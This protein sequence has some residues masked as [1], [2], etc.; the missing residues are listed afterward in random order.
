M[1][2]AGELGDVEAVR[3]AYLQGSLWRRRTPE[4]QR[5]FAWKIDPARAGASGCFGDIGI[6]AYNLASFIT[7]LVPLEVSCQLASFTGGPL[8]D[9]GSAVLR[10]ANGALGI[11]TASR[12]SHGHE[13]DLRIEVDGTRGALAWRQ[14]EPNQLF[15]SAN[16]RPH[17]LRVR[18][19]GIP[20]TLATG[21]DY[22]TLAGHP[23]GYL[24]AFANVY[25][26]A[27][28]DMV[29]RAAGGRMD[30]SDSVYPNVRDG[31]EG[32]AFVSHCVASARERG[33]W[34]KMEF[35]AP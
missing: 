14:E 24:D 17:Q 5:R 25:G 35:K 32:M 26:A 19:C 2:R 21:S 20:P 15:V 23:E 8:D 12:I 18:D 1:I 33:A 16:G 28:D 10:Y 34:M 31:L 7:G 22:R 13:N 6:H 11:L 27:F 29:L 9:Y 30:D 3:I 4:Q